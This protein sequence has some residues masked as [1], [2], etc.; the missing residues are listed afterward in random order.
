MDTA[1]ELF[2]AQHGVATVQQLR[3][4]GV[5]WRDQ[6]RMIRVGAWRLLAPSVLGLVGAPENWR[7]M[8]ATAA[9][10]SGP[11]ALLSHGAAARLHGLD[12]YDRYE[13]L[14]V[15]APHGRNR[16]PLDITF[17]TMV[18]ELRRHHATVD[19][20]PTASLP[21]TLVGCAAID[22]PG[23]FL[24]ALDSALRSG[25]SAGWLSSAC[26]ELRTRGR[27]GPPRLLRA[28]DQR[29]GQRLPRSWF[30]RVAK[31]LL[32]RHGVRTHDEYP[33]LDPS[34]ALLAELD[35]AIPE[36]KIGIECQSWRWHSTPA[37]QQADARRKRA[38]RRTGWEIVEIW[39]ADLERIDD[40]VATVAAIAHE[41]APR[42]T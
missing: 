10:A 1:N 24:R 14:H 6:Q 7:R 40:V 31:E 5:S 42:R 32:R 16:P 35:L 26:G 20:I 25:A 15:T 28:L 21:L 29:T 4:A 30:Q 37:N 18:A 9:L 23:Q 41:R 17:H 3:R 8:A 2:A 19:G 13:R 34:G 36:L 38:L 11:H 27:A 22:R 39:W 12:G 33:V